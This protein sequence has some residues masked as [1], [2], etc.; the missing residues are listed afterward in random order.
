MLRKLLVISLALAIAALAGFFASLN[1][2]VI[3]LDLAFGQ[4]EAPL[5]LV[6]IAC[7]AFGWV[8]GLLSASMMVFKMMAQRRSMRRSLRLAEK[9]ADNLRSMPPAKCTEESGGLHSD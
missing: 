5:T 2:S 8:L 1:P 4:I 7:L 3:P 9:E 6:I